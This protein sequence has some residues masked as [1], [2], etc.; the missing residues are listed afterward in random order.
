MAILE[1]IF[2]PLPILSTKN[3]TKFSQEFAGFY[4]F[5]YV[6]VKPVIL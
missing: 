5:E 1:K 4:V 2:T 6:G 3:K